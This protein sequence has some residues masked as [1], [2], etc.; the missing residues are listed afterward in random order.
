MPQKPWFLPLNS[1]S[2]AA[3]T[4]TTTS[5][6]R[7]STQRPFVVTALGL[8]ITGASKEMK[9]SFRT[10]SDQR[11][12]DDA[13]EVAALIGSSYDSG[14]V[15]NGQTSVFSFSDVGLPPIIL[16]VADGFILEAENADSSNA[17]TL[18]LVFIGH[19]E[20]Y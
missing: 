1:G 19:L 17:G 7:N 5:A 14:G 15:V 2:L 18:H 9:F 6:A 16:D 20:D 11:F 8:T 10:Q 4:S 13:I 12:F 3:S